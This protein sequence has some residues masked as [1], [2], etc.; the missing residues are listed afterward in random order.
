MERNEYEQLD[1]PSQMVELFQEVVRR[2]ILQMEEAMEERGVTSEVERVNLWRYQSPLK[3]E[4]GVK[5]KTPKEAPKTS[6]GI[7][8]DVD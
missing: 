8:K 3:V 5:I 4:A 7:D 1:T 2:N 6:D